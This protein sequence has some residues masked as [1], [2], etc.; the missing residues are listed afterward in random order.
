MKKIVI[1][2]IA[3]AAMSMSSSAVFAK[4][5]KCSVASVE[6]NTVTLDCGSKAKALSVGQTVK[7]KSAKKKAIEGC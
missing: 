1:T 5:V 4:T 3:V 6:H 7:V 2:L